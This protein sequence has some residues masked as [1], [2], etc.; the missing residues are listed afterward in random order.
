MSEEAKQQRFQIHRIY[1]KDISLE[2]PNTPQ[3]FQQAQQTWRP[4]INLQLQADSERL[5]DAAHEVVLTLTLTAKQNEQTAFLVELQQAGIFGLENFA[6]DQLDPML[7]AYCPTILFPYA[8]ETI[9]SLLLRAGFPPLQLAPV[10][11]DALYAQRQRQ[12]PQQPAGG[13]VPN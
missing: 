9:D 13:A 4:E 10:N 1:V 12:N 7:K 6:D 3:I 5:D 2:T 8:R 11:F